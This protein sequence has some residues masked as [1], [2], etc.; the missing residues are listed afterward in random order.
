MTS[1]LLLLVTEKFSKRV[2]QTDSRYMSFIIEK[3]VQIQCTEK[4]EQIKN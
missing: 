4:M 3:T 2:C 1:E